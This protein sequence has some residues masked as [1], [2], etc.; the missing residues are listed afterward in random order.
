MTLPRL[1]SMVKYWTENPP[2][3]I[4]MSTA[5]L[6]LGVKRKDKGK[7]NKQQTDAAANVPQPEA[8]KDVRDNPTVERPPSIAAAAKMI[9]GN[10]L[11][12]KHH[13]RG[14]ING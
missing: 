9:G 6:A 10:V 14:T 5:L 1:E 8:A 12:F 4:S 11:R 2:V 3:H 7:T 13:S